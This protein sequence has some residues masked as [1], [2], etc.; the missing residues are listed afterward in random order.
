[1][2]KSEI[3]IWPQ[4]TFKE[5]IA[6]YDE[7]NF[8]RNSLP[9][10]QSEFYND[11]QEIVNQILKDFNNTRPDQKIRFDYRSE[12]NSFRYFI[13]EYYDGHLFINF[14]V[15]DHTGNP[16]LIA[17]YFNNTIKFCEDAITA[18]INMKY[19]IYE[20]EYWPI[21]GFYETFIQATKTYLEMD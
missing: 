8:E 7:W 11:V 1:M 20:F 6:I 18:F 21:K 12:N 4:K 16:V 9:R 13:E 14:Y 3:T 2:S 5:S 15:S 17:T 10:T 19:S